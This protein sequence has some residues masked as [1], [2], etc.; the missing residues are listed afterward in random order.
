MNNSFVYELCSCFNTSKIFYERILII[1]ILL[2]TNIMKIY[3]NLKV[4]KYL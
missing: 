3:N 4:I 2:L 1:I